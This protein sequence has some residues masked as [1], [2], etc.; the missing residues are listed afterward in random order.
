L[1]ISTAGTYWL[2]TNLNGCSYRDSLRVETQNCRLD[3]IY[4]PDAFSPNGDSQNDRLAVRHAG[5]FTNY[6]FRVYDRWGNLIF[7]SYQADVLWDGTYLNRPCA[8]GVYA[9]TAD[10]SV[11]NPAQEAHSIGRSGRVM[12]VR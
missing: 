1:T 10:Y 5:T 9:W 7:L 8:E 12:L 11:F 4:V 2:E 3:D 6:V